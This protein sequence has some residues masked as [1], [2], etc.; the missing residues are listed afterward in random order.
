MPFD[1]FP[2]IIGWINRLLELPAWADPWPQSRHAHANF[3]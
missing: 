3:G 1:Q 2:N